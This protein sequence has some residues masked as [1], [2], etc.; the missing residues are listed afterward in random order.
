MS[1]TPRQ[2]YRIQVTITVTKVRTSNA[3]PWSEVL[4]VSTL[5]YAYERLDDT[6]I[7]HA[8]ILAKLGTAGMTFGTEA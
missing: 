6:V 8:G 5:N 7:A 1:T 2:P 3:L 4:G